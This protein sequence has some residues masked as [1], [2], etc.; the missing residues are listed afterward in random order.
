[1]MDSWFYGY[2]SFHEY[3]KAME[4]DYGILLQYIEQNDKLV[5]TCPYLPRTKRSILEALVG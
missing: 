3:V 1:L 4:Q 2:K 5:K